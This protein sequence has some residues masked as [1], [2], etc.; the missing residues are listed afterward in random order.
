MTQKCFGKILLV[1]MKKTE[2]TTCNFYEHFKKLA[3]TNVILEESAR[4]EIDFV[5]NNEILNNNS[6]EELDTEIT[7]DDLNDCLKDFKKTSP[8]NCNGPL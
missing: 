3:N 8:S 6:V 7:M 2:N 5:Q 4:E 1:E